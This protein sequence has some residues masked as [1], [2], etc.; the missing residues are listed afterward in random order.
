MAG[1]SGFTLTWQL[2]EFQADIS[3]WVVE[4]AK[5]GAVNINILRW[6]QEEYLRGI[7][8]NRDDIT[9]MYGR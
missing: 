6:T 9:D 5:H 2:P 7:Q 3:I 1:M 4:M 8:F